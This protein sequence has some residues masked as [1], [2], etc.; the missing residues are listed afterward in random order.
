MEWKE[1]K[2]CR[3]TLLDCRCAVG[4]IRFYNQ[5]IEFGIMNMRARLL[6]MKTEQSQIMRVLVARYANS[7]TEQSQRMRVLV[8]S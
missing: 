6:V 5:K 7:R 4:T 2:L 3:S 1:G 8:A